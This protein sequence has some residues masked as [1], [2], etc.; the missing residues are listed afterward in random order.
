MT[1]YINTVTGE[2]VEDYEEV[3]N[4]I[5]KLD[6]ADLQYYIL[7]N[8]SDFFEMC[9]EIITEGETKFGNSICCDIDLLTTTLYEEMKTI[10]YNEWEYFDDDA[11][12][13]KYESDD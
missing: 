5:D 8:Y 6:S 10:K 9:M 7:T 2:I 11:D 12:C 4:F 1:G 3:E 13:L